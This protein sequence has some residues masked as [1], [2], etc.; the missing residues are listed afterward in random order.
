MGKLIDCVRVALIDLS[1]L[2]VSGYVPS[3]VSLLTHLKVSYR[4]VLKCPTLFII[5]YIPSLTDKFGIVEFIHNP[6]C[7]A[8]GQG[9]P[10]PLTCLHSEFNDCTDSLPDPRQSKQEI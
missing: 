2:Q 1:C 9:G 8:G 3:K 7:S 4:Q 5:Q 6:V 10:R